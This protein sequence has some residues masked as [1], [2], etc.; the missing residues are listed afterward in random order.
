[1]TRYAIAL[2]KIVKNVVLS[3]QSE[4][5]Q[6]QQMGK[7]MQTRII[8]DF[9]KTREPVKLGK[10]RYHPHFVYQVSMVPL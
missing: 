2:L 10:Q 8:I 6:I 9:G 7:F 5:Q 3:I 1:M 4:I